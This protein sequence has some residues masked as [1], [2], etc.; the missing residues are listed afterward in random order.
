MNNAVKRKDLEM[1]MSYVLSCFIINGLLIVSG[2][3]GGGT[4]TPT[5]MQSSSAISTSSS[6]SSSSSSVSSSAASSTGL[7]VT[8]IFGASPVEG[9]AY[10]T[11]TQSGMTNAI[12][13]FSFVDGETVV[14][15]IGDID[16]P[17]V[18]AEL[19]VT[20]FTLAGSTHTENVIAVN[21]SRLL[22]T[23]D[24]NGDLADGITI[25]TEVHT[26]AQGMS[27]DFSSVS[28]D[29]DVVNLVSNSGAVQTVLVS[30][31][32]AMVSLLTVLYPPFDCASTHLKV[33]EVANLSTVAHSVSGH[34]EIINNCTLRIT[35]FN[36][37]GGGL[38]DVYIYGAENGAYTT[39]FR[40]GGNIFSNTF[41]DGVLQLN[42]LDEDT[43]D[44]LDGISVWC[45][46]VSVSF[47]DGVF[48][49]N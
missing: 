39:G 30:H 19:K 38:P 17:S 49:S 25:A 48:A 41:T 47:G 42:I 40:I 13:E 8:G 16:L 10:T 33:G 37:D 36:Y 22:Q 9:L 44:S 12:G 11:A 6:L 18:A 31:E 35:N 29:Q 27:V 21:V 45:E 34:A 5:I 43:L 28:F 24:T 2:C 46:G 4:T 3:G 23:L 7:T 32:L 1:K 15:S 14:F 26:Q 20:A